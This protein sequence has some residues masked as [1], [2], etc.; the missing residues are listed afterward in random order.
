MATRVV[1]RRAHEV[2]VGIAAASLWC[3]VAMGGGSARAHE[4][5]GWTGT[6][7]GGGVQVRV[8]RGDYPGLYVGEVLTGGRSLHYEAAASGQRL[9]GKAT[10]GQNLFSFS[11]HR[12]GDVATLRLGADRYRVRRGQPASWKE[13]AS[14]Q[15]EGSER[16][17]DASAFLAAVGFAL[18]TPLSEVE[19]RVLRTACRA[20]EAREDV[21]AIDFASKWAPLARSGR[22]AAGGRSRQRIALQQLVERAQAAGSREPWR[23]VLAVLQTRLRRSTRANRGR[24]QAAPAVG[25]AAPPRAT[26]APAAGVPPRLI[27][28]WFI[29]NAAIDFVSV[30]TG[31]HRVGGSGESWTFLPNGTYRHVIVTRQSVMQIAA[32][33]SGRFSVRDNVIYFRPLRTGGYSQVGRQRKPL[34]RRRAGTPPARWQI[35]PIGGHEYLVLNGVSRFVR[36]R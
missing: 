27:G 19:R 33:E 11:L 16:R 22:R 26:A 23:S 36:R 12:Q 5:D 13:S 3:G 34:G 17:L 21:L 14:E 30:S 25:R 7:G 20:R 29:G 31:T 24:V 1:W 35:V 4:T 18:G 32:Y 6:F 15:R 2:L 10:D 9:E 8:R 28:H